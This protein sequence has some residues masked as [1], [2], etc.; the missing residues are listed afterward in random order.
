MTSAV[1]S[2]VTTAGA[3]VREKHL[4]GKRN[5]D[6]RADAAR[7][8]AG[9]VAGHGDVGD[10]AAACREIAATPHLRRMLATGCGRQVVVHLALCPWAA[11][12]LAKNTL[13]VT[14]CPAEAGVREALAAAVPL[15]V[16]DAV[17]GER[18]RMAEDSQEAI[19]G[20]RQENAALLQELGV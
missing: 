3:V 6:G 17:E 10:V 4:A 9:G 15:I 19:C 13:R 2:A 16:W 12:T 8:D 5:A 18:Q 14:S 11:E 1:T 7:L 20:L